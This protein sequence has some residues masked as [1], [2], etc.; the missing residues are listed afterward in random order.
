VFST[1]RQALYLSA[2]AFRIC[3]ARLTSSLC[4]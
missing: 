4:R 3:W 2:K 1:V